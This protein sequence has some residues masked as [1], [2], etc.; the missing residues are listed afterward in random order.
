MAVL[1]LMSEP[2]KSDGIGGSVNVD[3]GDVVVKLEPSTVVLL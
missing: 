3:S 2:G 1:E